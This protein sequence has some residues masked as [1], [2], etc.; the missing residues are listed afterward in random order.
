MFEISGIKALKIKQESKMVH[1]I[2]M[3]P[4]YRWLSDVTDL[5]LNFSVP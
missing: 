3:C 2:G 1:L 5:N 4:I